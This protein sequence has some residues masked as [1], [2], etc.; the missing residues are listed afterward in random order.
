MAMTDRRGVAVSSTDPAVVGDPNPDL[1]WK[2]PVRVATTASILLTGL[3]TVDG[4]ALAD[5]DRVLVKNQADQST[6]GIYVATTGIWTRAQDADSNDKWTQG[7]QVMVAQ[8]TANANASFVLTTTNPITLDASALVFALGNRAVVS[9][10]SDKAIVRFNGTAGLQQ[11]SSVFIAD[12]GWISIGYAGAGGRWLDIRAGTAAA[13]SNQVRISGYQASFEVLNNAGTQNWYFGV[14][15]AD[16]NKL[17]IGGGRSPGQGLVPAITVDN[18]NGNQV[19]VGNPTLHSTDFQAAWNVYSG[20]TFAA[21]DHVAAFIRDDSTSV[22][23]GCYLDIVHFSGTHATQPS[24]VTY[25]ARGSMASPTAIKSGDNLLAVDPRGF[26]SSIYFDFASG[27]LFT[28]TQD[29][30][31]SAHG[32][33]IKFYTTPNGSSTYVLRATIDQD[34]TFLATGAVRSSSPTAGIGYSTGAG[35]TGTQASSKSTTVTLTPA[36]C[37]CGAVTMNNAALAAATIVSFTLTNTAIA[38]TDVLVLNHISGGTV[39][40][41]TLNAQCA[42]GSATINVRNNT[43]G[44]LSEAIVVQFVVI[45]G[46]NA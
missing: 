11:N 23:A 41:Y 39:G 25:A 2:T 26:D 13:T 3:Q 5:G 31:A 17:K 37:V 20:T 9:P 10:S 35:G 28:A 1:A 18:S 12:T 8:G 24:L 29:W 36:A 30:T 46:V 15:D 6:N 33:S 16:S 42:A 21:N 19:N 38:A 32:S 40:A 22:G 44:S 43:A 4:V 45:K 14:D 7:L 34:G 27:I